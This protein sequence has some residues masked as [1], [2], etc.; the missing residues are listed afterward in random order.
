MSGFKPVGGGDGLSPAQEDAVD[1]I[2]NLADDSVPKVESGILVES[3]AK[4]SDPEQNW[5][6]DNAKVEVA[7]GA[8]EVG[9]VLQLSEGVGD[10]VVVDQLQ[11][12]MSIN[13]A[14][15]FIDGVGSSAPT[16]LDFGPPQSLVLQ[17]V[18]T[19]ILTSNPLNFSITSGVVAPNSRLTD[20][21]IVRTNG[22]MTNFR[23]RVMD[24]V[25]GLTLRYIPSKAI[26]D[27]GV[28]GFNIG[29]GDI[30][31]FFAAIGTNT[32][33][34]FYLGYVPFLSQPAQQLDITIEADTVDMKGDV[35]DLPYAAIEAHD[36][37]MVELATT[38]NLALK[39]DVSEKGVANGYAGLDGAGLVPAAQLPAAL[40]DA[41]I[42]TQYENNADTNAF[43]DAEQ[44]KLGSLTGGRYLGV[45][46]DLTALQTAHPTGVMGDNAT[47]T[48]PDGNLF[49]WNG[50]AWADSGTGFI[51]DMLKAVYDPTAINASAFVMDNMTETA[52]AKIFTDVERSKL[53]GIEALAEVNNISD[54][55][56]T[57]LTDAGDTAL[58]FHSSDR[59]RANHTGTQTASTISDF[60]TEVSNNTS[61]TANT[62]KATNATHTG[63][64]TGSGVLTV[65]PTAISNK[66][67]VP[68]T[69]AMEIL[70]NDAG[71]LKK[72]EAEDFLPKVL[73]SLTVTANA[74]IDS[75]DITSLAPD[76][77]L[78]IDIVQNRDVKSF[79]GGVDGQRITISNLSVNNVKLKFENG[80]DEMFRTEGGVDQTV[81]DY[82]GF[83]V[84]YHAA[85]G[86]WYAT[87]I[88]I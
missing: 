4:V 32:T 13:V 49:Y 85:S 76:G 35:G 77:I 87:G 71:T 44:T 16:F 1:S 41:Q 15:D 86:F 69:A 30:T 17:P 84:I 33:T 80:I 59:A 42:K 28:G 83:T 6:F 10:L 5:L 62:A 52:T 51:G 39:Q 67:S 40:T 25:T 61:V 82:G 20:R 14:S 57:D 81:G 45:F 19:T 56:A 38:V 34:D 50:A 55:N 3:G 23:A 48:S 79:L 12:Q 43:T 70:V 11:N 22:P 37:P 73:P 78:F 72:V 66:T 54:V 27:A 68:A 65:G 18:D 60:D 9:E 7:P 74:N 53:S 88:N 21:F 2:I 46:A 29:T 64:V 63:E 26:W 58:H 24:N 31:F 8:V 47:V 75:L 36:G